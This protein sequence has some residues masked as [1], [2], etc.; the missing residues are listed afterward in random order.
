MLNKLF[1][2]TITV[3]RY[4]NT[5]QDSLGTFSS[6]S[7]TYDN[8]GSGIPARV[9]SYDEGTDYNEGGERKV[10]KTII[11]IPPEY[12]LLLQ[13]EVYWN[14]QKIGLVAGVNPGLKGSSTDI[15]HYEIILE[16]K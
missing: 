7:S 9:E 14:G 6:S 8:N 15:D 11:Y 1:I 5:G 2:H 4:S 12:I 13:D 10:N 3:I 16:N